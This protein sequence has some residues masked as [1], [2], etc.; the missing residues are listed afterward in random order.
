MC[1]FYKQRCDLFVEEVGGFS[2][3]DTPS[4]YSVTE[5]HELDKARL[6]ME[7]DE[8][9]VRSRQSFC[10]NF[11]VNDLGKKLVQLKELYDK[12]IY[13]SWNIPGL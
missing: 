4:I 1:D 11:S 9:T 6:K 13:L 2:T 7:G 8:K 5:L 10:T 12:D 3:V